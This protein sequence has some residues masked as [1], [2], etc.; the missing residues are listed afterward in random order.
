MDCSVSPLFF[1][2]IF[3]EFSTTLKCLD[4]T[5]KKR[6]REFFEYN[7]LLIHNDVD[8]TTRTE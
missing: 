8:N 2:L 5:Y 7:Y 6:I 1:V 4:E 3:L